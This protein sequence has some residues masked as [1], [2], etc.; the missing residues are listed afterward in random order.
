MNGIIIDDEVYEAYPE[1]IAGSCKNCDL[2]NKSVLCCS[3]DLC[4]DWRCIF[5]Y[6]QSLTDKLNNNG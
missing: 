5:R 6:S 2:K 4:G 1:Y 3:G